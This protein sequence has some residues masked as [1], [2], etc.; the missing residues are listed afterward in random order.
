MNPK[1][2]G[3]LFQSLKDEGFLPSLNGTV[4]SDHVKDWLMK[5]I[6]ENKLSCTESDWIEVQTPK[7]TKKILITLS[8]SFL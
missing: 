1:S 6:F 2:Y 8:I 5:N 4:Y 3:E 7:V